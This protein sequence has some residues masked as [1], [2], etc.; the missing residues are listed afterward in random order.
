MSV[1][2][3]AT[4]VDRGSRKG[5]WAMDC[6]FNSYIDKLSL[7]NALCLIGAGSEQR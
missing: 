2:M 3:G 5:M 1:G 6:S 7:L 4:L